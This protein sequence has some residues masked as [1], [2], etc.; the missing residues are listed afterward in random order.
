MKNRIINLTVGSLCLVMFSACG[1]PGAITPSPSASASISATSS[2]SVSPSSSVAPSVTP[3][4]S[5]S[6]NPSPTSSPVTTFKYELPVKFTLKAECSDG[7]TKML[8]EVKNNVFSYNQN[9]NTYGTDTSDNIKSVNITSAQSEELRKM[10]EAA[11]LA[12]LAKA[13][14]PVDPNAPTTM[15]CRTIIG[16]TMNVDG[17]AKTFERNDRAFIHSEAY[18][19]AFDKLKDQFE[20]FKNKLIAKADVNLNS[21]FTLKIGESASIKNENSTLLVK[22][23]LEESRCPSNVQCIQAGRALFSLTFTNNGKAEDF[24]LSTSNSGAESTTK[25]IGN[26]TIS[27]VKVSPE[28]FPTTATPKAS[29]YTLT[30]KVTK[31]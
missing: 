6:V 13:D 11:D 26:Y 17:T 31:N 23:L 9:I 12:N 1:Q 18:R 16:V 19:N 28:S 30:L 4:V 24:N 29:D 25:K 8:Y 22:S 10:I 15:E 20:E 2:P 27:L 7:A 21:E 14:Q 5:P 3:T